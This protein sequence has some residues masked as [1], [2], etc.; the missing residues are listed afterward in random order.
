MSA[1]A[2]GVEAAAGAQAAAA[3]DASESGLAAL[4]FLERSR[5]LARE[6]VPPAHPAE[7]PVSPPA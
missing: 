5:D 4:A 6:K 2:D 1:P 7:D 3:E